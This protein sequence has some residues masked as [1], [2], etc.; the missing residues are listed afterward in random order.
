[1]GPQQEGGHTKDGRVDLRDTFVPDLA[2]HVCTSASVSVQT[3]LSCEFTNIE[4]ESI[5]ITQR[6][7]GDGFGWR[8]LGKE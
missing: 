2:P 6:W 5:C 7:D 8:G 3:V 4:M 1:M